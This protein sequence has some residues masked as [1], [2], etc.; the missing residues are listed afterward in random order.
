MYF[1]LGSLTAI[2]PLFYKNPVQA[3]NRPAVTSL[4]QLYPQYYQ[5]SIWVPS[6]PSVN[7]RYLLGPVLI[8]MATRPMGVIFLQLQRT[9]VSFHLVVIVLTV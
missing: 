9:V 4:P 7:E 8:H 2:W 1:G 5:A 6:E 3:G